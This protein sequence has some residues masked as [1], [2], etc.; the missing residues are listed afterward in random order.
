MPPEQVTEI[1]WQRFQLEARAVAKLDHINLVRV[2][3]LGIHE[4]CLPYYAM[5]YVDGKNLAEL[6]AEQG[7]IPLK[8]MLEI[9]MQVCDRV[10]CAHRS[11][12]LH[13]D[14]KPANIM[15][16][17][18]KPGP[19]QAK[20]LDFGLAKLSKQDRSHQSL[21][22]VGDI[23]GSPYYMSPEQCN[24]D[25]LDNRSDIYSLGSCQVT[26]AN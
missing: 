2:T 16:V 23:F 24:G 20:V 7:P 22:A 12:I 14:L 17:A 6:L 13:R 11:G 25:K 9:F 5:D 26:K 18:S 19:K 3:D 10:E 15:I 8:A 1:G 4:G 21:T